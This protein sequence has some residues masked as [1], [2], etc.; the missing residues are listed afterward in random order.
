MD[1]GSQQQAV[2]WVVVVL[3]AVRADVRRL[4]NRQNLAPSDQA[5][6][7]VPLTQGVTEL[8]LPSPLADLSLN[9][10]S[11]VTLLW[12]VVYIIVQSNRICL[13]V[14]QPFD[15]IRAVLPQLPNSGSFWSHVPEQV[16]IRLPSESSR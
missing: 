10:L 7:A 9:H 8:L 5:T 4:K 14:G 16:V 6:V 13:F 11:P 3:S 12:N 1:I 15:I 2:G